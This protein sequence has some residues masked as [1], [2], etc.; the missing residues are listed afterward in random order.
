[1]H[2]LQKSN[3]FPNLIVAARF[4]PGRHSRPLDLPKRFTPGVVFDTF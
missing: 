4:V 3:D 1:M 2:M